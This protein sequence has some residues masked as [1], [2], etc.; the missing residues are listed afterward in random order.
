ME[1]EICGEKYAEKDVPLRLAKSAIEVQDAC[2]LSG[3]VFTLSK[4]LDELIEHQRSIEC[5]GTAWRNHHPVIVLFLNKCDSLCTG[6]LGD[7]RAF[8]KAYDLCRS[9]VDAGEKA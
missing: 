8:S 6:D 9:V 2:N 5:P 1:I 7:V 4:V 3:V